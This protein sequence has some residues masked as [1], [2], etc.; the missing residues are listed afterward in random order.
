[1]HVKIQCLLLL[2]EIVFFGVY[3]ELNYELFQHPL[4]QLAFTDSERKRKST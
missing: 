4:A 2:S 3:G 1:M